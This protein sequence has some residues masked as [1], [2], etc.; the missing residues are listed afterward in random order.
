MSKV[1][2][3]TLSPLAIISQKIKDYAML[4][5]LRLSFLVVFS[6][7][8]GYLFGVTGFYS[9]TSL[10]WV[11][12][13]GLLVTGA[14]NTINQIIEKDIDRLMARTQNRPLP[15]ER[16]NTLEAILAA[17]IFQSYIGCVGRS[18]FIDLCFYLYAVK[19]S[20]FRSSICRCN[21]RCFASDDW[22]RLRYRQ[23]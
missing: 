9:I 20:F 2:S 16:M 14:S 22:V 8:I 12:L 10:F 19:K 6:A 4:A 17:G 23:N 7:V 5:K 11:A 1:I 18:F 15:A 3:I 21:T 13:G